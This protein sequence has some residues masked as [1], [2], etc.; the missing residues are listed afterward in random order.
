ML[1]WDVSILIQYLHLFPNSPTQNAGGVIHLLFLQMIHN[2]NFAS[3]C[4]GLETCMRYAIALN[5]LIVTHLFYN[6][7]IVSLCFINCSQAI[8]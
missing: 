4:I 6:K 2:E 3:L 1:F 8:A 5:H 7:S